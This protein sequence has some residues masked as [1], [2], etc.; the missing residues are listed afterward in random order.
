M[1]YEMNDKKITCES[2]N[3]SILNLKRYLLYY[4]KKILTNENIT[5]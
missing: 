5:H 3:I 2:K 4:I 1:Y